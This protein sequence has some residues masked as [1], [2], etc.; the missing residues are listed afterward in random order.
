MRN[1]A[2]ETTIPLDPRS[3]PL[4]RHIV[5]DADGSVLV[6]SENGLLGWRGGKVQR[7]TTKNGLP[8]NFVFAFIQDNEK[9]WWLYT[10]CGIVGFSDAE[11]QKWWANPEAMIRTRIY[12][13]FDGA[14]PN[15]GSFNAAASTSD[16]RVWFSSG[17]VVQMLD[18]SRISRPAWPAAASI[19]S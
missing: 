4:N 17:V 2:V 5:A 6:S 10:R 18:P 9:H 15:I 13:V 11:L 1:G 12:D 7:M 14:Q 16:G 3:S 8:C 19:E